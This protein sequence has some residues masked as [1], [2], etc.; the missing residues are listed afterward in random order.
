LLSYLYKELELG[1]R[2][3][4]ETR[5]HFIVLDAVEL[6]TTQMRGTPQKVEFLAKRLAYGKQTYRADRKH[7]L[8][9]TPLYV[10][11]SD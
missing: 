4:E 9:A 3:E 11:L 10:A 7:A 6:A 5:V 2:P 1:P 8:L